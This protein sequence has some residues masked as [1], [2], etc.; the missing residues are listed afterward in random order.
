MLWP[1]GMPAMAVS[2]TPWDGL[3]ELNIPGIADIRFQG[4]AYLAQRSRD[5]G[6]PAPTSSSLAG[7]RLS[8]PPGEE[9]DELSALERGVLVH[10]VME[11]VVK[12]HKRP[13][14]DL[15][16]L[17]EEELDLAEQRGISGYPLLWE[18][19]KEDIRAGLRDCRP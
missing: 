3:V 12:E 15:L 14:A 2:C 16:E 5:L 9:D 13:D 19:A 7:L 11:R 18:L 6:G 8:A 1:P 17:A 10:R 4:A